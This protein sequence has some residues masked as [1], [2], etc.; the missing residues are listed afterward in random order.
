MYYST[1]VSSSFAPVAVSHELSHLHAVFRVQ[2]SAPG[3]SRF[4]SYYFNW[5]FYCETWTQLHLVIP[6]LVEFPFRVA[7]LSIVFEE[8]PLGTQTN[9]DEQWHQYK[10]EQ[11]S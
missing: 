11:D 2:H 7:F 10:D 3:R 8:P 9:E 5:S 6:L 1:C 4:Y